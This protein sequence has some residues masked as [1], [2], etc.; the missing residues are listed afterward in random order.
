VDASGVF[1]ESKLCIVARGPVVSVTWLG[2]RMLY[3]AIDILWWQGVLK[4]LMLSM[5][6]EEPVVSGACW[7]HRLLWVAVCACF[8][9][10]QL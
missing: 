9:P 1:E 3:T 10:M 5:V 7:A 6:A 8:K 2:D 4:D